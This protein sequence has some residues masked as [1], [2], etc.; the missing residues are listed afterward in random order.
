MCDWV[1]VVLGL[2][3]C[4]RLNPGKS[5]ASANTPEVALFTWATKQSGGTS[6]S[7]YSAEIYLGWLVLLVGEEVLIAGLCERKILFWFKIYDYLR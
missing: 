1:P 5:I 4:H 7:S 6:F 2:Y 3:K